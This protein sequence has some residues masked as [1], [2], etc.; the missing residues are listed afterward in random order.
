MVIVLFYVDLEIID[1]FSLN[2][3]LSRFI[4]TTALDVLGKAR[5]PVEALNVFHTMLVMHI[6]FHSGSI[7]FAVD[8]QLNASE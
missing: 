1:N 4:Y 3:F 5:R 7:L 2:F 6:N 8:V